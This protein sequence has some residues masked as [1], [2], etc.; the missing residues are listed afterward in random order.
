MKVTVSRDGAVIGVYERKDI[1]AAVADG[2]LNSNDRY[3]MQGM[4][5][6]LPLSNL[7]KTSGI[8]KTEDK[9][10]S[11]RQS[12]PSTAKHSWKGAATSAGYAIVIVA[13]FAA[14]LNPNYWSQGL[15]AAGGLMLI[16][17]AR[18]LS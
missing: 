2:T 1:K 14:L 9:S 17:A 3:F 18:T 6:W 5:E 11:E 13:G 7:T 15:S 12:I 16:F 8:R 4:L 10:T